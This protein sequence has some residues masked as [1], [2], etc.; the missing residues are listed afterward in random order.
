MKLWLWLT[1]LKLYMV[2]L[3]DHAIAD[4]ERIISIHFTKSGAESRIKSEA[5]KRWS[6]IDSE[7]DKWLVRWKISKRLVS[8]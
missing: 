5:D 6:K 1:R 2:S 8:I 4:G 3:E 7:A